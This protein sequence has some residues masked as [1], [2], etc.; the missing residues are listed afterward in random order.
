MLT[1]VP[2]PAA[3]SRNFSRAAGAY[4]AHAVHQRGIAARRCALLPGAFDG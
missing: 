4:D 2:D 3:V 1:I